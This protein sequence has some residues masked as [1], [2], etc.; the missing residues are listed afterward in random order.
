MLTSASIQPLTRICG[1]LSQ[2]TLGGIIG[3]KLSQITGD[4][5][6]TVHCE[7]PWLSAAHVTTAEAP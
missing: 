7:N 2:I 4:S 6:D 3:C 1:C 5:K